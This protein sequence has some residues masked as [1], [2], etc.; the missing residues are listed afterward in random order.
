VRR[1]VII[2]VAA[3]ILAGLL[4]GCQSLICATAKP[5]TISSFDVFG[6]VAAETMETVQS[7]TPEVEN[8]QSTQIEVVNTEQPDDNQDNRLVADE[9]FNPFGVWEITDSI[10]AK[11]QHAPQEIEH[12]PTSPIR[13]GEKLVI[14]R[15]IFKIA[16]YESDILYGEPDTVHFTSVRYKTIDWNY[17]SS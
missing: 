11:I 2:S 1:I 3:F 8:T 4:A 13:N 12:W 9:Y 17:F 10:Q 16:G 7:E 15:D 6:D 5:D 14:E